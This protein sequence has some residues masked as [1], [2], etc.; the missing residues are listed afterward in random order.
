MIKINVSL[1]KSRFS[2]ADKRRNLL[3]QFYNNLEDA[4]FFSNSFDDETDQHFF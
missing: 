2:S 3:K 4:N 1:K